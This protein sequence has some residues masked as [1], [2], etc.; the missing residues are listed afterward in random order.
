MS[1]GTDNLRHVVVLMME[2]RS[3]DPMLGAPPPLSKE[4]LWLLGIS[5][6]VYIGGKLPNK[7]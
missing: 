6:G 5:H 3:F 7:S 4:I 1:A 2:T